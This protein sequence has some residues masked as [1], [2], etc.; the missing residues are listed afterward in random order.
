MMKGAENTMSGTD[1]TA[2]GP[3]RVSSWKLARRAVIASNPVAIKPAAAMPMNERLQGFEGGRIDGQHGKA[4]APDDTRR[5][6]GRR[7]MARP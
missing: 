7:T 1:A 4:N 5:T 3:P 6:A 2:C